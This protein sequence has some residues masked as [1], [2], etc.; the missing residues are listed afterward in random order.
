MIRLP[1]ITLI[2]FGSTD[3]GGMQKALDY[4]SKNIEFGAVKL[5]TEVPCNSIDEWNKNV[6]YQLGDY[7]DTEF[8]LL[9]HP[10]GFVVHPESWKD[11]WLQYDYIG[12]PWPFPTDAYSYRDFHGRIQRVG[13]SVS[14]R[15]KR[16][17]D[18]PKKLNMEWRP[19]FGFTNEDG[20][21]CV[22]YRHL[23]EENGC[24]Y[25]PF[26]VALHF[27]RETPLPENVGIKPFVFH[28]HQGENAIY[29][30]FET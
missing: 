11:E 27:G 9:I 21:I 15:S 12:S 8:A 19:F 18:L 2:A 22:N 4:S 24:K 14:L 28:R 6:F 10:D 29:P 5:I 17:L 7:V 25:A 13:N 20:A 26:D 30:N 23:F 3:I 1:T 16:L